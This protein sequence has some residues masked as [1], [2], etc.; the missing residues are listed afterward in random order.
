MRMLLLTLTLALAAAFTPVM[1]ARA[2]AAVARS[3]YIVGMDRARDG[4]FT[5]LVRV[6]RGMLGKEDF[7]SLRGEIITTHTKVIRAFVDTSSSPLGQLTLTALFELADKDGNGVLDRKEFADALNSLGFS[8]LTEKQI[9]GIFD[10]ADADGNATID[11]EEFLSDA[12][13]TLRT[14]LVKL[15]KHNG[16]KLGMLS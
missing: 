9:D 5:P 6:A 16:A 4:I 3:A 11:L 2:P 14:N 15:A 12:P 7:D 10:R 8:H 1:P 13:R